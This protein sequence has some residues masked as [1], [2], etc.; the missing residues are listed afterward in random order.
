MEALSPL[1]QHTLNEMSKFKKIFS[2]QELSFLVFSGYYISSHKTVIEKLNAALNIL[3]TSKNFKDTV[4]EVY[5][6][7]N[8][9]LRLV[10]LYGVSLKQEKEYIG[11][12]IGMRSHV[13]IVLGKKTWAEDIA[14]ERDNSIIRAKLI[15]RLKIKTS[16]YFSIGD[17]GVLAVSH[18]GGTFS[19]REKIF[20]KTFLTCNV[21]PNLSLA[22]ENE[23]NIQRAI[24]DSMT[25]LYNHTYFKMRLKE[26]VAA[27]D[28]K[29]GKALSLIMIDIDYFKHYNDTNGHPEGDVVIKKLA[30]ILRKNTRA[31]DI[32]ARYGGEEFVILLPNTGTSDAI[33]KADKIRSVF[34]Q[35]HFENQ[36]AQPNK[37]VTMS[38]GV[39]SI[40]WHASSAEEL[41]KK[42]DKALYFSKHNGKNRV[43]EYS[44]R[45]EN[46]SK[47]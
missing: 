16:V 27:Y 9:E 47:E 24:K 46:L 19:D 1:L 12:S 6:I 35:T 15:S 42:A 31:I 5:F 36:E 11:A 22:I 13:G 18:P 26:E 2:E 7:I 37:N 32:P 25:N 45:V 21:E 38:V 14:P 41:L 10:A 28:R 30:E 44:D 43:T 34:E 17:Y 23:T 8:Q 39:A 4:M 33:A 29:I 40:P 3:A 20:I